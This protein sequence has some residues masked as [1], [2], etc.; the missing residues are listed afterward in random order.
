MALS[1]QYQQIRLEVIEEIQKVESGFKN[2]EDTAIEKFGLKFA[3]DN[4]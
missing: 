2:M 1:A 3:R 4:S